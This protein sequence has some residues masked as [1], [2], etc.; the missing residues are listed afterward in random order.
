MTKKSFTDEELT[1]I[2]EDAFVN[3]KEA[4]KRLQE[5]TGCSNEVVVSMLGNVA[6]FYMSQ[7]DPDYQDDDEAVF[8]GI[9]DLKA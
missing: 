5:R 4:C 7:G 8:D 9:K 6:E 1:E 3:V 2:C